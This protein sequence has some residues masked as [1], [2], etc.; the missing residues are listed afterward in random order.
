MK[1]PFD[2]HMIASVKENYFDTERH[3][4]QF[5]ERYVVCVKDLLDNDRRYDQQAA[6]NSKG[7]ALEWIQNKKD[8]YENNYNDNNSLSY[9]Q[10]TIRDQVR[11][12]EICYQDTFA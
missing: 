1:N 2:T 3:C 12:N 9:L 10:F 7:D 11:N 6:F 5:K 4:A 8:N